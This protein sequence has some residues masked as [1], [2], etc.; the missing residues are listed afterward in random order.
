MCVDGGRCS[1]SNSAHTCASRANTCEPTHVCWTHVCWSLQ[2][3]QLSWM[4]MCAHV[5]AELAGRCSRSNSANTRVLGTCVLD[6][7]ELDTSVLVV[8]A[9]PTQHTCTCTHAHVANMHMCWLSW[10]CSANTCVLVVAADHTCMCCS[11]SHV[12]VCSAHMHMGWICSANTRVL[13][14]LYCNDRNCH[15]GM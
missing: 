10:M 4:C 12:H 11:R 9:D 1:R 6:T 15:S 7:W 3:I 8:A 14:W 5:L 2:Q 13:S